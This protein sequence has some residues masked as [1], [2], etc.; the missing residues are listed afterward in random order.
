MVELRTDRVAYS[1]SFY[2]TDNL[3]Y[4]AKEYLNL[5][6]EDVNI[7]LSQGS[8]GGAIASAM[9]VLAW[10][11]RELLHIV[12]RKEGETAHSTVLGTVNLGII[13]G[14]YVACVVDDFIDKGK[15]VT[16]VIEKGMSVLGSNVVKYVLVEH[17]W[18]GWAVS[19]KILENQFSNKI[20]LLLLDKSRQRLYED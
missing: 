11:K 18:D 1:N 14:P 7:L 2:N 3:R 13:G 12:V 16:E 9:L 6:P 20:K 8:S 17:S 5:L 15:T 4:W 19:Q 10:P